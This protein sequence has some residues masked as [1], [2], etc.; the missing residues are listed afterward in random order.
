MTYTV[1]DQQARCAALGF[2]PGPIDGKLGKRTSAAIEAATE[3]QRER[4]KPLFHPSGLHRVHWH[5]TVGW[6]KPNPADRKHYHAI[7][8]GEGEEVLLH[9][10][11]K[12][13]AHTLKANTGAIGLSL[14]GMV[15]ANERPFDHGPEPITEAAL[16][17]LAVRTAK[18]CVQFDI[19]VSRWSTLSH[20]EIQ[21]SLAIPQR[22]KWDINFLPGMTKPTDPITAGDTIRAM[23]R[24]ELVRLAQ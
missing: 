17:A 3:F 6:H 24:K 11:D 19:P 1:R 13:L 16:A 5:W 4:G 14:C 7:F 8:T 12:L 21:P 23:V 18:L 9:D 22:Q 2:W 15:G 20:S 10:W